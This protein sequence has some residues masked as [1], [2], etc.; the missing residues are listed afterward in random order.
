LKL[1][2]KSVRQGAVADR[3]I[4]SIEPLHIHHR[5]RDP[6]LSLSEDFITE[7]CLEALFR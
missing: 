2:F 3:E 4:S 7:N 5:I 6:Y 1:G